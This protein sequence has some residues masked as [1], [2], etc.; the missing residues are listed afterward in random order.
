[1]PAATSDFGVEY[2]GNKSVDGKAEQSDDG[3]TTAPEDW[4]AGG[5]PADLV[6]NGWFGTNPFGTNLLH[7]SGY[8]MGSFSSADT[9]TEGSSDDATAKWQGLAPQT[10]A[11][12]PTMFPVQLT[13]GTPTSMAM[14]GSF[15][16]P[17]GTQMYVMSFAP[18]GAQV[19]MPM[20]SGLPAWNPNVLP[21]AP[22]T[23]PQAPENEIGSLE[24][25]AA[26]LSAHAAEIRAAARR[27]KAAAAAARRKSGEPNDS[28]PKQTNKFEDAHVDAGVAWTAPDDRTTLLARNLPNTLTAVKRWADVTD[29]GAACQV[30]ENENIPNDDRT[31]LM[32]RNLPNNYNRSTLLHMLDTEGLKG[33]YNLVYLPTDFRNF[34]GFGYAFVNF[35]THDDAVK[36][37]LC[38][39]GFTRWRVPS[40]K[41]CDVVWSGPVQ[42]LQA[43]TE[44][45]RNSPVMHDSVPDE[46]KPAVFV[47]GVRVP[48]PAPTK[49]V[50]PPR[51]RRN[52]AADGCGIATPIPGQVTSSGRSRG[53]TQ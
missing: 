9:S 28:R 24:A 30:D 33:T 25:R 52:S 15:A 53:K 20:G 14:S 32:F 50:R 29:A 44:R 19:L 39:Q 10:P 5:S 18:N 49:R 22:A 11:G 43:H 21:A 38:F 12:A 4:S 17:Q 26:A 13:P 2:V 35:V 36:A 37:K 46:Y 8:M 41:T 42:G 51:V 34:A 47:D 6:Q 45:Y 23:S 7:E 27:A 3:S 48:F 40:R 31:T 16:A 1:M